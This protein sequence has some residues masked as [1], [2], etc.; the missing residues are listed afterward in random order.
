M[1]YENLGRFVEL[2]SNIKAS[3]TTKDTH[4]TTLSEHQNDGHRHRHISTNKRIEIVNRLLIT[5][6]GV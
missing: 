5:K 4:L 6:L 3:V 1:N 2:K